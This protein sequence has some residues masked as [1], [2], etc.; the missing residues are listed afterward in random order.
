MTEPDANAEKEDED[1]SENSESEEDEVIPDIGS[2]FIH[3]ALPLNF[4][5]FNYG[6]V[7]LLICL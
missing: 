1:D 5:L 3:H 6:S 7:L 4:E 2:S